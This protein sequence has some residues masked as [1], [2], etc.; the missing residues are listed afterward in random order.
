[1]LVYFYNPS[2]PEAEVD[3]QEWEASLG[4]TVSYRTEIMGTFPR[5]NCFVCD[6]GGLDFKQSQGNKVLLL[7][8][9]FFI[10]VYECLPM[11]LYVRKVPVQEMTLDPLKRALQM[12]ASHH[13]D[14]ENQTQ[15]LWSSARTANALT[16]ETSLPP[17]LLLLF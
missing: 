11:C 16:I 15:V 10:Y 9:F 6:D 13:T 14:A 3:C 5:H 2:T 7:S 1:M 4:Y 8:V 17:R 12:P